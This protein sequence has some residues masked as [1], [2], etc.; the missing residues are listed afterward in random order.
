MLSMIMSKL[1]VR[2]YNSLLVL[3]AAVRLYR[4]YRRLDTLPL[5]LYYVLLVIVIP[6]FLV[7]YDLEAIQVLLLYI[8]TEYGHLL[9]KGIE[10]CFELAISHTESKILIQPNTNSGIST[11][12]LIYTVHCS[13]FDYRIPYVQQNIIKCYTSIYFKADFCRFS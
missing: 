10:Y 5:Y 9:L 1:N 6:V 13:I 11:L 8:N 4:I 12:T 7:M 2:V 3:F